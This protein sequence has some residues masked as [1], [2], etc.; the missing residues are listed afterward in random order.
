MRIRTV[1]LGAAAAAMLVAQAP[2]VESRRATI[3]GQSG[4]WGKC[5]I[6]VVV[7]VAADVEIYGDGAR[8][9]TLGGQPS[10]WRRMECTGPLTVNPTDFKFTGVDGRGRQTLVQDPRQNRGVA[11]VRIEDSKGGSEG[12][13]FDIEWRGGS[14]P[15]SGS[16]VGGYNPEGS[17]VLQPGGGYTPSPQMVSACQ[18][19]ARDRT[20]RDFGVRD[21]VFGN[22][23]R[24]STQGRQEWIVGTFDTG[25]LTRRDNFRF[26][27]W[28]DWNSGRVR[29]VEVA[30][31]TGGGGF[32]GSG[33]SRQ[34]V[35]ICQDAATARAQ[36]D[37]YSD[38]RLRWA[39]GDD[40]P[41][42]QDRVEGTVSARGRDGYQ[43]FM[44]FSCSMDFNTGQLRRI[45]V[46]TR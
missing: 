38:V 12:Y 14:A 35:R 30:R 42:R 26:A 28:M 44:D 24:D 37:G 17:G 43:Y 31:A 11:V 22:T 33:N 40:R 23:Y 10:Q 1:L 8:L 32:P 16:Y 4:D 7:D 34:A 45:D 25:R 29:S 9:R 13:T 15:S 41:G 39:E 2:T 36:Q 20:I 27:C 5:T 3:R 19:A 21:L 18:N 46:R 6:E